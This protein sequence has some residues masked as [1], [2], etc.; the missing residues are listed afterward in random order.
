MEETLYLPTPYALQCTTPSREYN[1]H[2]FI[3]A[4]SYVSLTVGTGF[5]IVK[6]KNVHIYLALILKLVLCL[7]MTNGIESAVTHKRA[8]SLK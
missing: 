1:R 8:F 6:L 7:Q 5:I 4:N 3:F 2:P